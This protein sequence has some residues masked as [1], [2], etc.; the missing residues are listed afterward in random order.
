MT[1][2]QQYKEVLTPEQYKKFIEI[3][4]QRRNEMQQQRQQGNPD[5]S[6]SK[7]ARKRHGAGISLSDPIRIQSFLNNSVSCRLSV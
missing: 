7:T 2:M 6:Q 4:E 3:Q 1:A 5:G